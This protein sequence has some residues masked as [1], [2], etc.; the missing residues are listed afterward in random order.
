MK[1]SPEAIAEAVKRGVSYVFEGDRPFRR[2]ADFLR[3]LREA[4][5]ERTD[6]ETVRSRILDEWALR[7]NASGA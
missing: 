5:W 3:M 2:V 1:N 7:K 4:G 6:L